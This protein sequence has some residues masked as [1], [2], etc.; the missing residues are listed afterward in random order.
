MSF[1]LPPDKAQA[2]VDSTFGLGQGSTTSSGSQRRVSGITF[3]GDTLILLSFLS[4]ETNAKVRDYRAYSSAS[5]SPG[6]DDDAA[7]IARSN[8][9]RNTPEVKKWLAHGLRQLPPDLL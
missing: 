9:L 5:S 6:A 7:W 2:A 3:T 1:F 4:P 8:E